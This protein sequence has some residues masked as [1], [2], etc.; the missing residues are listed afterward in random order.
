MMISKFIFLL[1]NAFAEEYGYTLIEIE[2]CILCEHKKII[3]MKQL[4]IYIG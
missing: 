1:R 4:W 2:R 3:L